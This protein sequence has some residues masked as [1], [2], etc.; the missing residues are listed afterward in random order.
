[1]LDHFGI[2]MMKDTEMSQKV[3]NTLE[4][5]CLGDGVLAVK[6]KADRYAMLGELV[7]F[8]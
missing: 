7:S 6:A 3:L 5:V 8:A 1:M 2:K 4:K